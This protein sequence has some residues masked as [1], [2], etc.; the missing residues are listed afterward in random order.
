MSNTS[1]TLS[2]FYLQI[3]HGV[4][5]GL[6]CVSRVSSFDGAGVANTHLVVHAV[7]SGLEADQIFKKRTKQINPD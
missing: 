6:D 1:K 3:F 7:V 4:F 2:Q 5:Q